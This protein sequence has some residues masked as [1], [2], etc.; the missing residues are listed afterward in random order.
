MSKYK[1]ERTFHFRLRRSIVDVLLFQDAGREIF[2]HFLNNIRKLPSH[3][4]HPKQPR[5]VFSFNKDAFIWFY[6]DFWFTSICYDVFDMFDHKNTNSMKIQYHVTLIKL[7][8]QKKKVHPNL[9]DVE[10]ILLW[11]WD[12]FNEMLKSDKEISQLYNLQVR[13]SY[14]IESYVG[15]MAL[16]YRTKV[17]LGFRRFSKRRNGVEYSYLIFPPTLMGAEP[18][19]ING[20]PRN[21][22]SSSYALF[23]HQRKIHSQIPRPELINFSSVDLF[24]R[25]ARTW[26][27]FWRQRWAG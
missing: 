6:I 26:S 22:G 12:K 20:Q 19:L 23:F 7:R 25:I 13:I 27:T 11:T 15:K 2:R 8:Y 3:R 14:L 10:S 18:D 9:A 17:T 4:G 1:C 24:R 16:M 21:G 5:Y